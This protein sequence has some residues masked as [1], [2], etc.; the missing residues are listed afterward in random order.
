MT[1]EVLELLKQ[2]KRL[3]ATILLREDYGL[4]FTEAR[5]A[6]NTIAFNAG[7]LDQIW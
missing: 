3:S 2:G 6:I 7:L 1:E 5:T 4:T